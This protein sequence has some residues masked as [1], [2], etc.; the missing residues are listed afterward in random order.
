MILH[1]GGSASGD[2][3]TRSS[4]CAAA[5][6]K[7]SSSGTTPRC[8]PSD[9]INR[10]SRARIIRLRRNFGPADLRESEGICI[11]APLSGHWSRTGDEV[12]AI[13]TIVAAAA[14]SF[15]KHPRQDW[16]CDDV[17]RSLQAPGRLGL[18]DK[19]MPRSFAFRFRRDGTHPPFQL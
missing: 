11:L 2:T 4:P 15:Q 1:T 13:I 12:T 16:W 7:A 14:R 19:L 6:V 17:D 8:S 18:H 5:I 9:P 10:T 3:S